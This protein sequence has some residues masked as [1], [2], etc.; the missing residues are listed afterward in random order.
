M[1]MDA[2]S[3]CCCPQQHQYFNLNKREGKEERKKKGRETGRKEKVSHKVKCYRKV[4][5][6]SCHLQKIRNKEQ[7]L[8]R[9]HLRK[10]NTVFFNVV[11]IVK[12]FLIFTIIQKEK[13]LENFLQPNILILI[14]QISLTVTAPLKFMSQDIHPQPKMLQSFYSIDFV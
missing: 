11:L 10:R 12:K 4:K 9:G 8:P 14:L 3:Q 1:G 7:S 6:E 2:I 13:Q 5:Q